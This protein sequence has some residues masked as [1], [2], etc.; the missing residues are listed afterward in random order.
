MRR[1][2]NTRCYQVDPN[3]VAPRNSGL[4]KPVKRRKP[5]W[6]EGL[7]VLSPSRGCVESTTSDSIE[8]I[9]KDGMISEEISENTDVNT[10]L[11]YFRKF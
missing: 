8:A 7:A 3:G 1:H 10:H 11:S 9:V 2:R 6:G 5:G 4:D